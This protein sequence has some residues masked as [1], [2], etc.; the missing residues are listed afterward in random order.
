MQMFNRFQKQIVLKTGDVAAELD[1]I[2]QEERVH[3]QTVDFELLQCATLYKTA[4]MDEFAP[5]DFAPKSAFLLDAGTQIRQHYQVRFQPAACPSGFK[6]ALKIRAD[7]TKSYA[8]A[9][10]LPGSF[11]APALADKEALLLAY[12]NKLKLKNGMLI[13]LLDEPLQESIRGLIEAAA[14]DRA[15]RLQAPFKVVLARW[16]R[17][18]AARNDSLRLV[19]KNEIVCGEN[20]RVDHAERHYCQNVKA[21]DCL[22]EYRPPLEGKPGRNYRGEYIPA[23]TPQ[24]TCLPGFGVD[25][26]TIEVRHGD[27]LWCYY[28]K[29]NGY[30]SLENN[31][32]KIEQVL[33]VPRICLKDTG[34]IQTDPDEEVSIHVKGS[35]PEE[36][37]VGSGMKLRAK[38]IVVEG[39][40]GS[41]AF[42]QARYVRIDGMVH[43]SARIEAD[44][45]EINILRGEALGGHIRVG[46][47]EGGRIERALSVKVGRMIG[48]DITAETIA[49]KSLRGGATL[50]AHKHLSVDA[51]R[52][53][54]NH[55]YIDA[56]SLHEG[57]S[58]A[59][60][61]GLLQEEE[62]ALSAKMQSLGRLLEKSKP[63]IHQALDQIRQGRLTLNTLPSS[64]RDMVLRYR[65]DTQ[66]LARMGDR[67]ETVK[68][69]LL[70][71]HLFLES[72]DAQTLETAI[73][74][75]EGHIEGEH[76]IGWRFFNRPDKEALIDSG[77]H[78]TKQ[79]FF[80]ERQ[81]AIGFK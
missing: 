1:R 69:L 40:V 76:K 6:F 19:Y 20:D 5:L 75:E 32:L 64:T 63:A 52:G 13:D 50:R 53:S 47:L 26:S 61:A 24:A 48:G 59:K 70:Q 60:A 3:R 35:S 41:Q 81:G 21:G 66:T 73:A 25:D 79:I 34:H 29:E 10:V 16:P 42:L 15:G 38:R 22:V 46:N 7:G 54:P 2:A 33:F 8:E 77:Y 74:L 80:D 17:P 30:V 68:K 65:E 72:L 39:S 31:V 58:E 62:C 49:V 4:Q 12:F 9:L 14:A 44:E 71:K 51:L 27:E 11:I 36:E 43:Q 67:L 18:V 56:R 23:A 57:Q 45:M 78:G 37:A 28:A 55:L